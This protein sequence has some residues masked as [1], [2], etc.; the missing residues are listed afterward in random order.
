MP[1]TNAP[2]IPLEPEDI[3]RIY[4]QRK[5]TQGPD[6]ERMRRIQ[7]IMNNEMVLPLP[8]LSQEEHPAVANL[9]QQ[10]MRQLARRIASVDPTQWFPSLNPGNESADNAALN[11]TRLISSWQQ[12][13]HL[14]IV[15]ARRARQFLAYASA[16]V[17]IKPGKDGI[18]HWHVRDP[19]WTFPAPTEFF[20]PH[21][22]DCIFLTR[23]S[24]SWLVTNYPDAI[25][26]VTKPEW[27]DYDDPDPDCL[28]DVL[29]Y[30][31]AYQCRL[32][33]C[34]Y[35]NFTYTNEPSEPAGFA[36]AVDMIPALP[37]YAGTPLA[38]VPGSVNLD[39]QAIGDFDSI[40]GMYQAQAALMAINIV[41]QRRAV[42]PREW[43]V[44]NPNEQ[45]EVVTIPDPATGTPGEIKGGS[46]ETQQLDPS[47]RTNDVMDRLE[48]AQ[49]QT[50]GLPPEFGGQSSTNIRT[51][52][53]GAQVLDSTISFTISE[54]QD[55]FAASQNCENRVA[56]AIDKGYF[57]TRKKYFLMT[58]SFAGHLEY[59]PS[60]LW[61]S[62]KHIVEYPIAGVDMENLPVEGGQRVAMRTMSR[63]R[64][65]EVDPAIPDAEAENRR[66]LVED[67]SA[68]TMA[69]ISTLA[70]TPDAPF[71]PIDLANFQER[72]LG[73]M[74]E[75]KAIQL[76]HEEAQARQSTP[77]QDPALQQPGLSMPGTG[78]E[79]PPAIPEGE[80]SMQNL[81]SLLNSLG[82]VQM[83]QKFR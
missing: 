61:V 25:S 62:D 52:R 10:G 28:F 56:I 4:V 7:Q 3:Y 80:P 66:I 70:S 30:V 51:G 14:R 27:W 20:D 6:I 23:H 57:D 68:A 38:V 72:I 77:T 71:G 24:Y 63:K 49:R 39:D 15:K 21:P 37:N 73:G 35:E 43:A 22:S 1:D 65:M 82:S 31:D 16:P 17:I 33:L 81:T 44:S 59:T 36:N 79:Q 47:F 42:W 55:V 54:A 9:A 19:L 58:R 53:R 2:Y 12:E 64:F 69:M 34:G 5:M 26:A 32:I 76:L 8:E 46:I 18:P 74:P 60:T 29:E 48:Y 45:V 83:A 41:A 50:A 78:A 67:I 11:R 40:I 13:N 75:Y